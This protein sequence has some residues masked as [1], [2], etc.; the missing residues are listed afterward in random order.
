MRTQM[1]ERRRL[2]TL[3]LSAT[4]RRTVMAAAKAARRTK[5]PQPAPVTYTA[6]PTIAPAPPSVVWW[7]I[8]DGV[9][10]I[11]AVRGPCATLRVAMT[12]LGERPGYVVPLLTRR[13]EVAAYL[14]DSIIGKR[15]AP[16]T[17]DAEESSFPNI[18][19]RAPIPPRPPLRS[20]PPIPD[21]P[22][23]PHGPQRRAEVQ[24]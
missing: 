18:P 10:G 19:R 11:D 21:I 14:A 23:L 1:A 9:P 7:C 2:R 6:P 12:W 24:P 13:R 20:L 22:P 8:V 15:P 5:A 4:E 16:A 3:G 17:P